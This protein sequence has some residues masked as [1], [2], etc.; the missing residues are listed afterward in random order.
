MVLAIVGLVTIWGRAEALTGA[1]VGGV[2][3]DYYFLPPRGFGIAAPEH[4]VALVAF[5]VTAFATGQ[6]AIQLKRRQREAMDRNNEVEKLHRLANVMLGTSGPAFSLAQLADQ[7]L[8]IFGADGVAIYDRHTEGIA[9]AG[10]A[11]EAISDQSLRGMAACGRQLEDARP[12]CVTP[13]C[14]GANI[15]GSIGLSA[16]LSQSLRYEIAMQVGLGLARL[17]SLE[18]TLQGEVARRSGELKSAALDAMAHD[19]RDP[20]NSIK[21]A[22]TLLLSE[23]SGLE[24]SDR[25]MLLIIEE[26]VAKLDRFLNDQLR[27]GRE[28]AVEIRLNKELQNIGRLIPEAI[29]ELGTA[30][31]RRAIEVFL[32]E[33]LPP[34]ECDKEIVV[35]V[36]K[37]LLNNAL[38]YSP[39]DSPLMVSAEFTGAAIVINVVDG[40]PG[41]AD[42]E[43]DRIFEKYY[44]GRA[45]RALTPGTGLGLSSARMLVEAHGG[46][47]W[48]TSPLAGGAAFHVSLPV[49]APVIQP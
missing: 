35:R 12:F 30:A 27:L 21:I 36:L 31:A 34:T 16:S 7:L 44:R 4:W 37:Q 18:M 23:H 33:L 43:R 47:I 9:R 5:V 13:I 40:G 2:G 24:I 11:A 38:K 20:L 25:E 42:D 17:Y 32:P 48:M 6:L 39:N 3:Y 14:H 26:E 15:V 46:E 19:A 10:P 29:E 45:S 8:A 22:A 1:V 28:D 49:T 41:V